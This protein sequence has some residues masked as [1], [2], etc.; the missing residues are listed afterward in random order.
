MMWFSM[1]F[2]IFLWQDWCDLQ[3]IE[4]PVQKN[5]SKTEEKSEKEK[6]LGACNKQ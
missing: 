3:K 6:A 5:K 1:D 4:S 2:K